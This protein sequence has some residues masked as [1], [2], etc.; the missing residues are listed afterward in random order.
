VVKPTLSRD[1]GPYLTFEASHQILIQ[2]LR[3]W[4]DLL[5]STSKAASRAGPQLAL[6]TSPSPVAN[7][8]LCR[9]RFAVKFLK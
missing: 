8:I 5:A 3:S 1:G 9:K 7:S 6:L 4:V 2:L